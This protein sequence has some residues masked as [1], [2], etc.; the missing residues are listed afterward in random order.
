MQKTKDYTQRTPLHFACASFNTN[1][2]GVVKCLVENGAQINAKDNME[3][4]PLH[5]VVAR[6]NCNLN[7]VKYLVKNGAQINSED[8][9]KRTPL[10]AAVANAGSFNGK[11]LD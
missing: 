8:R 4:T 11:K 3:Q 9:G 6:I 10:H 1:T 7:V 2:F 5:I